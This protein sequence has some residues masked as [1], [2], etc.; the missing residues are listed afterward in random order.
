MLT[1]WSRAWSTHA[2]IY[3]TSV[4]LLV[5]VR[6]IIVWV[7]VCGACTR[8]EKGGSRPVWDVL[9]WIVADRAGTLIAAGV[10]VFEEFWW[11]G[12]VRTYE[13]RRQM[14]N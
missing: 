2:T 14:R 8:F 6:S 9:F 7:G 13:K 12:S 11:R 5:A 4:A 10:S 1:C 3:D